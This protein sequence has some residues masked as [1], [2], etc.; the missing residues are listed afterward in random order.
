MEDVI[1]KLKATAGELAAEL[2]TLTDAQWQWRAGDGRWTAQEI[3][4]HLIL[5]L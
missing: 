4:E 1:S 2:E 5:V 3:V